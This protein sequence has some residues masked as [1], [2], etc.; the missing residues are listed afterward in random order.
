MKCGG[1][2][3]CVEERILV[4]KPEGKSPLERR[5]RRWVDNITM[6]L[7]EIRWGRDLSYLVQ[8]RDKCRTV[9]NTVMNIKVHRMQGIS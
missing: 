6:N 3:L 8:E 4:G 9:V 2:V 5:R 7:Q 1:H